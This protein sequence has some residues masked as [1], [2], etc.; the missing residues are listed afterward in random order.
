[1]K[2]TVRAHTNILEWMP[3]LPALWLFAVYWSTPWACSSWPRVDPRPH[4]LFHRLHIGGRAALSG[5]LHSSHAVLTL[6]LGALG[7][8]SY[9]MV[10]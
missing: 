8:I 10:S 3:I 2:R 7:R 4:H 9:L 5:L 6:L 1:L